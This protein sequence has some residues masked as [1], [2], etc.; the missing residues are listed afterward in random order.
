MEHLSRSNHFTCLPHTFVTFFHFFAHR[1]TV[2]YCYI[3]VLHCNSDS[4]AKWWI[5]AVVRLRNFP[6]ELKINLWM[7]NI[8]CADGNC[9]TLATTGH[10]KYEK[11]DSKRVHFYKTWIIQWE[12]WQWQWIWILLLVICG[13]YNLHKI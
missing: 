8:I 12:Q 2:R 10:K 1:S 13:H 3:V 5:F 9:K 11:S 4:I 6:N 7:R